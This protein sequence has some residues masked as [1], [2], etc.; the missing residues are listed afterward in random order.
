M[1]SSQMREFYNCYYAEFY[2][3]ITK[4]ITVNTTSIMH[5]LT[6]THTY[7]IT[8]VRKADFHFPFEN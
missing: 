1:C 8:E 2:V 7:G 6:H 4:K 3:A 5:L